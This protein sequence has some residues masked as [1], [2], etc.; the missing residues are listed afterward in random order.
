MLSVKTDL[1]IRGAGVVGQVL[2]LLLARSRIRVTLQSAQ[3]APIKSDIR[4]FAL[5]AA[6]KQILTNLRVWPQ[7]TTPVRRMRVWGGPPSRIEFDA[8]DEPL[9]WIV[10]ATALQERLSQ[11]I[12]F[13]S[14]IHRVDA[15][16]ASAAGLTVIC[17]GRMSQTRD[18]T[19]AHFEQF[20]YD[21]IA[22]A[23]H[24]ICEK[25]HEHTAVQWMDESQ[26]CALLPRGESAIGNSAALV[27]SVSKVHASQLLAMDDQGFAGAL[28]AATQHQLGALQ[29][30]S[31]RAS[32]P[33][34]LAQA[35]QWRGQA[36]WGDWVLAGDAAHA[37]HPLA[38]QGLNLGLG[39][40]AELAKVLANKPYYRTYSDIKLL[41]TYERARKAEAALLRFAVDGLQH[42]F[43]HSDARLQSLRHWGMKS[44]D[45][46]PP[47]KAWLVRQASGLR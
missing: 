14:E 45:A 6:S 22:I 46:A 24:I 31:E 3:P 38:G 35:E 30:G 11:A 7:D 41:R 21:Q 34:V 2:A 18:S 42:A 23:A 39:D 1:C 10:D 5:N 29:M 43:H 19:G 17:E 13:A 8:Q 16:A 28:E 12:S 20:P 15:E 37:L 33:L 40:A 32:W 4:S 44:L 26:V 9:A 36:P 25:P 47:L 27:W